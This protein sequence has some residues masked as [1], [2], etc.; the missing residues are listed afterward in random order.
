MM[1]KR[2]STRFIVPILLLV[3]D[4]SEI[5]KA[6]LKEKS[7][8]SQTGILEKMIVANGV[9][10]LDV[11][12]A[13]FNGRAPTE[14]SKPDTLRFTIAPD[15][16]FRILVFDNLLRGPEAGS[17]ALI[18][19]NAAAFPE[20]LK[21]S[22]NQLVIEKAASGEAFDLA[23]LDSKTGLVFFTIEG[24]QYDYDASKHLLNVNGARLLISQ[25]FAKQLGHA[26]ESGMIVGTIS[27]AL[28]LYPIEI[29]NIVNGIL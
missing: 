26:S 14:K 18:S 23:L 16:F 3:C 4:H 8:Q 29:R 25:E 27:I 17:M 22:A 20:A 1:S 24:H 7:G 9:V 5:A 21:A 12:L 2:T 15:S 13:R 11:D 28:T 6:Q 19:Q 10:A